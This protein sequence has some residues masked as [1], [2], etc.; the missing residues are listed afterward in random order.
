MVAVTGMQVA[1]YLFMMA[2]R[3]TMLSA[4]LH[5]VAK[6]GLAHPGQL[7]SSSSV[8]SVTWQ[9]GIQA[10]L[11]PSARRPALAH[12]CCAQRGASHRDKCMLRSCL[13][14]ET[15]QELYTC[16]CYLKARDECTVGSSVCLCVDVERSCHDRSMIRAAWQ[17]KQQKNSNKAHQKQPKHVDL[18]FG[19]CDMS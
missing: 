1:V 3:V 17:A 14:I 12:A 8:A 13:R 19:L 2:C 7:Q 6:A 16:A 10:R 4:C 11:A 18:P 5:N 15:S 9:L